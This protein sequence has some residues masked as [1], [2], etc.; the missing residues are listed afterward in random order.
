MLNA[1][2]TNHDDLDT[3]KALQQLLCREILRAE[4]KIRELKSELRN[5]KNTGGAIAGKRSSFLTN[6]IEGVRQSAYIWRCFGDAIA[7]TYMDKFALKQ[8]FYS[9]KTPTV[10]QGAGFIADKVGLANEIALLEFA[11]EKEVPAL[12]VDLTNTIRHGDI[13]LMGGS[14]PTL[15]EVKTSQKLNSRG[16]KQ[17]ERLDTLKRFFETDRS[18]GLRGFPQVHRQAF[19]VPERTYIGDLNACIVDALNDGYAV[20]S[21][22]RGLFYIVIAQ[23]GVKIPDVLQPLGLKEPWVFM[24]NQFK[25]ERAWAP[26]L[27]FILA[28]HDKDHLWGFI[29]GDLY[30]IVILESGTLCQI[31]IEN[32]YEAKFDQDDMDYP[33][34]IHIPGT[35]GPGGT[36]SNF[37]ARIGMEFVSPEWAVLTSIQ[38]S[39]RGV[40]AADAERTG[41]LLDLERAGE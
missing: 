33:L 15:I 9:T 19:E 6:R 11:L 35:D 8:C 21:P 2:R 28:I 26:Y 40:E 34:R 7:F 17:R 25:T 14:D 1:L 23:N 32:G 36:S 13:C 3:L 20:R 38:M 22:E 29:R 39:K 4:R 24:L 37:L 27:P 30:I 31:A 5:N 41:P 12:L 10:Q 18:D 16:R